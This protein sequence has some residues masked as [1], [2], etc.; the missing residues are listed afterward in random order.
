MTQMSGLW[1]ARSSNLNRRVRENVSL[2]LG[3]DIFAGEG[4]LSIT[5]GRRLFVLCVQ[6][7]TVGALLAARRHEQ[8][9]YLQKPGKI[10]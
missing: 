3:R 2:A 7:N 8:V 10:A 9:V 5:G 6:G 4:R 1:R